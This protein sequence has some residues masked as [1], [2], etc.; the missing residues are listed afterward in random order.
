[1]KYLK[2]KCV[3]MCHVCPPGVTLET[4]ENSSIPVPLVILP[5]LKH[6]DLRRFLIATR[7]GDI[8][9]VNTKD[10]YTS[11]QTFP[12]NILDLITCSLILKPNK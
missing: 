10:K 11:E 8:P 6:G 1:M 3:F 7:Y 4:V 5:F 9:M 2:L 12:D